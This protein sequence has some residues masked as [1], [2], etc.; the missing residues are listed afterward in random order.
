MTEAV[1]T[2]TRSEP[3]PGVSTRAAAVRYGQTVAV[4]FTTRG[5]ALDK[6]A[7]ATLREVRRIMKTQRR[8]TSV[9]V[10]GHTD[11]RGDRLFNEELS[12]HRA[13]EVARYLVWLGISARRI[14][15]VSLGAQ[16]PADRA[17]TQDAWARN[18]RVEIVWRP[19]VDER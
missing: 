9:V 2:G 8:G 7:Q 19:S 11:Q 5:R 6:R 1:A 14:E 16:E 3:P 13:Q 4:Y 10:R 17:N 12:A 15:V 18:R